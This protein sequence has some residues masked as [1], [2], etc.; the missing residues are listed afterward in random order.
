MIASAIKVNVATAMPSD[1]VTNL[2][3]CKKYVPAFR[4]RPSKKYITCPDDKRAL[5]LLYCYLCNI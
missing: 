3:E 5:S 2:K 4:E 1:N